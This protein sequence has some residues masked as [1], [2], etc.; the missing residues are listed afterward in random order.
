[1][2]MRERMAKHRSNPTCAGCHSM[3]DPAGFA[4]EHFDAVGQWRSAD[5][6]GKKIDASGVLPDGTKYDGL[7]QFQDALAA[8][9]TQFV[10]AF[11]EKLL[12]Y[13]LGRGLEHYDMPA[14]RAIVRDSA[15]ADYRASAVVLAL[16]KSVPFQMR[17]AAAS[18]P[19][20]AS[21]R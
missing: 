3:I 5:Y 2:T 21:A 9:Q 6:N 11:A 8:N 15:A 18:T 13:A 17:R 7:S 10:S 20:V 14:L 12:I 16:V 4:L 19:S 1:M